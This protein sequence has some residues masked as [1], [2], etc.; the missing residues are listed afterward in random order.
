MESEAK[1][2]LDEE[3][4][5]EVNGGREK[6]HTTLMIQCPICG[7]IHK[8]PQVICPKCGYNPIEEAKKKMLS[9]EQDNF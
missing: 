9:Q 4:I 7:D 3:A 8:S 6:T 1:I 2:K 5:E